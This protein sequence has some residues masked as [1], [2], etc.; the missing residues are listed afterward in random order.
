MTLSLRQR[1][2]I[3]PVLEFLEARNLLSNV[4]VNNPAEDFFHN[5]QSETSTAV[6]NDGTIISAFND[7]EEN[8][9]ILHPHATGY[10]YSTD[11]GRTFTDAGG[12]PESDE[13][14]GGDTILSSFGEAAGGGHG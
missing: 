12:L 9:G 6:A 11:G 3:R 10:A 8:V 2:W 5:T 1:L 14:D 7:T 4:A 13:G